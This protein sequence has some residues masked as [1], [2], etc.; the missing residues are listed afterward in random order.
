MLVVHR[1]AIGDGETEEWLPERS[2]EAR[3]VLEAALLSLI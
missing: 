1:A 3:V 2:P